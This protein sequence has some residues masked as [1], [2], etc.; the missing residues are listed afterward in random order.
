M[1]KQGV[2]YPPRR[3]LP[4]IKGVKQYPRFHKEVLSDKEE[5]MGGRKSKLV[6]GKAIFKEEVD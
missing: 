2:F 1:V 4:P 5:P 6:M 3:R